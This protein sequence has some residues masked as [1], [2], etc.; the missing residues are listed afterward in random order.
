MATTKNNGRN[1][2]CGTHGQPHFKTINTD[3]RGTISVLGIATAIITFSFIIIIIVGASQTLYDT[4]KTLTANETVNGSEGF[5]ITNATLVMTQYTSSM[6]GVGL[7]LVGVLVIA[8]FF[9][10]GRHIPR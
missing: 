9:F 3:K 4:T 5:L 7:A 2:P 10:I 8:L 1:G 6:K